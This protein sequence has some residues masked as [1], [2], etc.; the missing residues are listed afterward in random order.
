MSETPM[1]I[2]AALLGALAHEAD[3]DPASRAR[4]FDLNDGHLGRFIVA[5]TVLCAALFLVTAT[6]A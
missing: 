1:G 6:N 5:L 2:A 4:R 3:S